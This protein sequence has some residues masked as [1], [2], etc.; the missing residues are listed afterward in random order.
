MENY[1]VLENINKSYMNPSKNTEVLNGINMQIQEGEFVAIVGFSGSG[2][3][4]LLSII[5]NM[6]PPTTGKI[7]FKGK[8]IQ[9]SS[10]SEGF[11]F[12]NYSLL[13]HL[14]V[15]E[16]VLF[17]IN[18]KFKNLNKKERY[19]IALNFIDKVG[20]TKAIHKKPSELSGGMK[21]RV[22]LARTLA[23]NPD[24]L[25]MDEPLGALDALTRSNLQD[26]IMN[27][28][29]ENK[30]TAVIVTNNIEEAIVMAD[31][32]IPLIST[33]TSTTIDKSFDV[34]ID[35][36]KEFKKSLSSNKK[37]LELKYEIT[38]YLKTHRNSN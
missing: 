24:V 27:I 3:S 28:W 6:E 16:N 33:S 30:K 34:L 15:K 31:R 38:E 32:V 20:L 7:E 23:V 18:E 19:E 11:V 22:S 13:P 14:N 1:I 17:G 10:I 21:Q 25:L 8:N 2:K 26:E 9:D 12:Q 35:K 37:Y 5:A 4:T 29:Q 36:G